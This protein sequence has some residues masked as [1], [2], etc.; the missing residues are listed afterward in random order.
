[1]FVHFC[2]SDM[3][4]VL[5]LLSGEL[6]DLEKQ[7]TEGGASAHELEKAKKRLEGEMEELRMSLEV[8]KKACSRISVNI[9][10][11]KY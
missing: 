10:T 9:S 2:V 3:F 7:L 11:L 5:F 4:V 6:S 8:R 1:M